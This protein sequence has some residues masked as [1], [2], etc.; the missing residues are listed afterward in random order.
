MAGRPENP[1]VWQDMDQ[2][3]VWQNVRVRDEYGKLRDPTTL[4]DEFKALSKSHTASINDRW[5][6]A[7]VTDVIY[8]CKGV[9]DDICQV[10]GATDR[11]LATWFN[12]HP[13]RKDDLWKAKIG[14]LERAEDVLVRLLDSDREHVRLGAA[15]AL[16]DRFGKYFGTRRTPLQSTTIV[17][18]Q[19]GSDGKSKEFLVK[20]IF[21]MPEEAKKE[22]EEDLDKA[23]EA[24]FEDDTR[25][26][27]PE[28]EPKPEPEPAPAEPEDDGLDMDLDHF[29]S[30]D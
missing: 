13:Q 20:A 30:G 22:A 21:G 1:A 19:A 15:K 3:Q 4:R 11:M 26:P 9:W 5:P 14:E 7:T 10:L 29:E 24:S 12:Q 16:L 25:L 6:A 2:K 8:A 23:L 17:N 27:P 18:V 28:P